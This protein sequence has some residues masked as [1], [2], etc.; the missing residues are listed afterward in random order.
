MELLKNPVNNKRKATIATSVWVYRKQVDGKLIPF[1]NNKPTFENINKAAIELKISSSTI[2]RRIKA[3]I[4]QIPI[5]GLV[6]LSSE[7]F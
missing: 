7:K 4:N 2:S 3:G 1:D 6:F 5:R